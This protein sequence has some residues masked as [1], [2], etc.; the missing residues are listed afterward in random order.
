MQLLPV[1]SEIALGRRK[2]KNWQLQSFLRYM[3]TQK[4]Q[5]QPWTNYCTQIHK[6]TKSSDDIGFCMKCF[7]DDFLQFCST[8][9]K[10]CLLGYRL[11]TFSTFPSISDISWKFPLI[12]ENLKSSVIWQL[13]RSFSISWGISYIHLLV[14]IIWFPFTRD[15]R[16]LC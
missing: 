7:T 9:V 15:E 14:I 10:I 6:S 11:C 8:I 2:R 1:R 13:V 16:K 5:L 4:K 12:S 3:Q